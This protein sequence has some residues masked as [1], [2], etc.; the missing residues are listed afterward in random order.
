MG[1]LKE[2]SKFSCGFGR[3]GGGEKNMV[4]VGEEDCEFAEIWGQVL[5]VVR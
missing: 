3:L 5:G 4:G 2:V 1:V